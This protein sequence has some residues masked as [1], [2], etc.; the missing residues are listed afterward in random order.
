MTPSDVRKWP[1]LDLALMV[2][3]LA[4]IWRLSLGFF[5]PTDFVVWGADAEALRACLTGMKFVTC[6]GLSKFP[7]AYLANAQ[8][9]A[10]A[11]D[12][13]AAL[14]MAALCAPVACLGIMQGIRPM[15]RSGAIYL[16]ALVLSPL[17]AFYIRSGAL[18]LQ[19]G[20][21]SGVFVACLASV[22]FVRSDAPVKL[23]TCI[24][25]AVSGLLLPLYKDT[26]VV[27]LGAAVVVVWLSRPWW[28]PRASMFLSLAR[29]KTLGGYAVLPVLLGLV[30]SLAYNSFRFG[31]VLPVAY[32]QEAAQTAPSLAQSLEFFFGSIMS[33]NG[34]VVIFWGLPFTVALVGWLIRG[35]RVD[36]PTGLLA[37]IAALLSCLAFAR[38]WAPFGWDAWGDRL[39]IQPMLAILVAC[40]LAT[41]SRR[42]AKVT[43]PTLSFL[44]FGLPVLVASAYYAL[45]PYVVGRAEML[46]SSLWPGAACEQ[47]MRRL[48]TDAPAMGL[49]F[50]RTDTYYHCARERMLHVPASKFE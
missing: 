13:L 28:Q 23:S 35:L 19:A 40:L 36:L 8:L 41:S 7:L 31:S 29:V 1:W 21:V 5:N 18:E 30:L 12:R 50:W 33:P 45:I 39:M 3:S 24:L 17:P 27:L 11:E 46:N 25:L 42:S 15:L 9:V 49:S 26:V 43:V 4:A 2:I 48:Q 34:G 20:V 10:G 22:L 37:A 14:N 16:L 32:M 47:M 44:P 38:W 6:A